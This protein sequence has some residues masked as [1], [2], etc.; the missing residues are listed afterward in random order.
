[1]LK[2][3]VAVIVVLAAWVTWVVLLPDSFDFWWAPAL[4]TA[5]AVTVLVAIVV[6]RR[7]RARRAARELEKALAAQAAEQARSARP[8]MQAEILQMQQE[9]Q[10]AIGALKSSKLARGGEDALYALPWHVIIGPPGSGKSTALRNSG[11]QFPYMSTSG[12]GVRGIGGTRNCDWWLTNEAVLLDTAGRWTTE[13]EDRDEW[14]SFLDLIKK[15]RPRKPLNGIVAAVSLDQLGGAHEEEV[16]ALARRMRERIDEVQNRLQMS[17]PVYVLFTKSDLI[18]GFVETFSDLS[19][20]ERGQIWGFTV[21]LAQPPADARMHF[22]ERFDE[23]GTIVEKRA[24]RRM[25]EERKLETRELVHSFPQQFATLRKSCGDFVSQLFESSVFGQTPMFRGCYF[26]SGTQEG[27]PIDRVMHKM[28]EAFGIRSEVNLGEP[29]TEAKSY[30]LRDVFTNVVF[31]D[32]DVASRSEAELAR[33]RRSQYVAAGVIFATALLISV[34]P[35]LAWSNN[36]ELLN[37]TQ[38]RIDAV[39]GA[40]D[41]NGVI[42]PADLQPL[43]ERVAELQENET[44]GAP[45][46]YRMGMYREEITDPVFRYYTGLLREQV[47]GPVV[48]EDQEAMDEFGRRYETLRN[49][50]PTAAEHS[51]NYDRLRAHLLV[52]RPTDPTEPLLSENEEVREWVAERITERWVERSGGEERVDEDSMAEMRRNADLYAGLLAREDGREVAPEQSMRFP[53]DD[54]TVDRVRSALTRVRL[55]EMALDR[56]IGDVP[57]NY[58]R[59]LVDLVGTVDPMSATLPNA[60]CRQDDECGSN[61]CVNGRCEAYVRGAFTRAAWDDRVRDVLYGD[62]EDRLFGER[63]VLGPQFEASQQTVANRAED[64]RVLRN[65]YFRAYVQEW[66]DFLGNIDVQTPTQG[67]EDTLNQRTLVNLQNLTRGTPEP[68]RRL[69]QGVMDNT[70][71][72]MP[73]EAGAE[74]QEAANA[75]W[76]TLLRR[77]IERLRGGRAAMNIINASNQDAEQA[78]ANGPEQLGPEHVYI[79]FEGFTEFG[80]SPPQ[81]PPPEGQP[82]PPPPS[83]QLDTYEEQLH[84]VRDALHTHLDTPQGTAEALDT[85]LQTARTTTRALIDNAEVGWRPR[86]LAILWPPIE[87]STSNVARSAAAGA[88]RSWCSEVY[89]PYARNIL[90]GYPLEVGGHDIPLADFTAFYLPQTGTLWA[91][92][93]EVL[94]RRIRREGDQFVFATNLGQGAG[95]AY[96]TQLLEYLARAQDISATFFPP[97]AAEGPMV[98]FDVRIRPSVRVATQEFCSSGQCYEYHNGPERWTRY[99]WPGEDPVAGAS[100]EIRGEGGIHERIEQSGEWG[101]F[102]LLE[103]GT[104]TQTS[105]GRRVFTM[106]WR[107]R[108]HQV[109][110]AMDIRPVRGDAP[111][112]GVAGHDRNPPLLQPLRARDVDPPSEIANGRRICRVQ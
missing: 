24:L 64:L 93:D 14:M 99:T 11:L 101:L 97:G 36:N 46:F 15:F 103:Q 37:D 47:V 69:F 109:D 22:H 12:G 89:T 31:K 105:R 92:Y 30:F 96:R 90:G 85:A 98:Q 8:D 65:D 49:S 25:G 34:L 59:R 102:R 9:F 32:G 100:I 48:R 55:S 79:A 13:E 58:D 111:F 43:R 18:P 106:T 54:D 19:K 1:M 7:L 71:L 23:L 4:F 53:R 5:L 28:A 68:Y 88:G 75:T 87:G 10:R 72:P 107:L 70:A 35:A 27:R 16:G 33:Q 3:I 50:T 84:T 45:F 77:R 78:A 82:A 74:T 61:S 80:A 26:S 38:A 6:A 63:W 21:P 67:D 60:Q 17:L 95:N 76:W 29:V 62:A 2:Y 57:A 39:S 52:T 73:E 42:S 51:D 20:Q 110:V 104:V 81:P 41:E 91:F 83:V 44:R 56:L 66:N 86:L 40:A 94:D 108:D 112:F